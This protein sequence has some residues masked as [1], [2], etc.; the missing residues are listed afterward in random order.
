MKDDS[1]K[2]DGQNFCTHSRRLNFHLATIKYYLCVLDQV[3]RVIYFFSII[4]TYLPYNI[5]IIKIKWAKIYILNS[6]YIIIS[7]EIT[8][9]CSVMVSVSLQSAENHT[10]TCICCTIKFPAQ[11]FGLVQSRRH[12][13]EM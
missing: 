8:Y 3:V 1:Y 7:F 11:C 2:I 10:K 4:V 13:I 6:T 9:C 5:A 12:I